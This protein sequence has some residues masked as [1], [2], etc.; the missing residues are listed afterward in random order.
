M[1]GAPL[2]AVLYTPQDKRSPQLRHIRHG[3]VEGLS[4]AICENA[5]LRDRVSEGYQ[6]VV[7]A[8]AISICAADLQAPKWNFDYIR[9]SQ[10]E[11]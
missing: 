8:D 4:A 2:S 5:K 6:G 11:Y 7:S 10:W 3:A 1:S 9:V